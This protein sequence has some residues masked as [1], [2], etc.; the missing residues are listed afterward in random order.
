PD[1]N[2]GGREPSQSALHSQQ[3]LRHTNHRGFG[4]RAAQELN[5]PSRRCLAGSA[6]SE[7]LLPPQN[8]FRGSREVE[9]LDLPT[10]IVPPD[11]TRDE[12]EGVVGQR[13]DDPGRALRGL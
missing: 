7:S 11:A 2:R 3:P 4:D 5:L 9:V 12:T 6:W 8:P 13:G 1:F 10:R